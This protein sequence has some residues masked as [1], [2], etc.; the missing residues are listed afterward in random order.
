M[1][2]SCFI[3]TLIDAGTI[4]EFASAIADGRIVIFCDAIVTLLSQLRLDPPL[5]PSRFRD[6]CQGSS[7]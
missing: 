1:L 5:A 3:R 2:G 4:R 7:T 6:S